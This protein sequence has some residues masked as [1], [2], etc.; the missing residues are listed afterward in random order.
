M[1]TVPRQ[2]KSL[3]SQRQTITKALVQTF[4]AELKG[5]K[6]RWVNS[7][8]LKEEEEEH[9]GYR[10][11]DHSGGIW[12]KCLYCQGLDAIPDRFAEQ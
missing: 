5:D 7:K 8:V 6:T 3:H 1:F 11:S 10:I 12:V 9:T 4:T 2:V